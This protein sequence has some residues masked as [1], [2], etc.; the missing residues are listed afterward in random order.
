MQID[1]VS[2]HATLNPVECHAINKTFVNPTISTI[3]SVA[4]HQNIRGV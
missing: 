3:K 1:V 4:N 2:Q